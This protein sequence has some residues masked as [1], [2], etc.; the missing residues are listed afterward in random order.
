M[1]KSFTV[2]LSSILLITTFACSASPAAHFAPSDA[3]Y[4]DD[5]SQNTSGWTVIQDENGSARYEDNH[6]RISIEKADTEY[7]AEAGQTFQDDVRIEVDARK[8]GGPDVNYLGVMC[9][10]QDPDNYYLF[11]I[12]TDGYSAILMRYNG[13]LRMISPGQE[14]LKMDGINSGEKLNHLRVDCVG[15]K[16]TLYA[17]GTQVSLAYDHTLVGGD[18]GLMARSSRLEGGTDIEFDNFAV[19]DPALAANP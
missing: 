13:T 16:L 12:T 6:Y 3:L 18:V 11:L 19:Y 9:R 14:F 7:L 4:F 10:Y 5:F 15:E 17:N 1:R 8:V 2:I